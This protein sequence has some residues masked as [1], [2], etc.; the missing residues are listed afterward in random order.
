MSCGLNKSKQ[1]AF[2]VLGKCIC[3]LAMSRTNLVSNE[4]VMV[5]NHSDLFAHLLCLFSFWKHSL[6]W[7]LIS[8]QS[9][10]QMQFSKYLLFHLLTPIESSMWYM[11]FKGINRY[12]RRLEVTVVLPFEF[13]FHGKIQWKLPVSE[14]CSPKV[15]EDM[16]KAQQL[17]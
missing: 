16:W 8:T 10:R 7:K 14:V 13:I 1:W 15:H 2:L 17:E 3:N 6:K 4:N 12:G 9:L 5:N 11:A